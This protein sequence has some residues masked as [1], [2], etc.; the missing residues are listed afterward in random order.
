MSD[1]RMVTGTGDASERQ[2]EAALRPRRLAEYIGQPKLKE[3]LG[4]YLQ[5]AARRGDAL[6]HVLLCGPPGLGKTTLAHIIAAEMGVNIRVT[7]GPLIEKAGDL[8]ALLTNLEPRDTLFIDEIHRLSPAVEEILYP[9]MEDFKLDLLVGQGPGARTITL[10]LQPFTLIGATTRMG[11][12]SGPLR[13]RFGINFHMDFY[14]VKDLQVIVERSARLLLVP[15]EGNASEELAR[16]SRGTPRVANRLLRRVRDYAQ[17]LGDGAV[18]EA[19][20]RD[21][22]ERMEVDRFGLDDVDRRILLTILEK[23]RGGPVGLNTIAASIGEEADSVEEIYEPY[24]MQIGFLERTPR[25]RRITA[26]A[27]EHLGI[28]LP[29]GTVPALFDPGAP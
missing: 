10:P 24:L 8:A 14:P 15:L 16:R 21:S 5:A 6:D 3:N 18:D 23:F 17:I 4:I 20:A 2:W 19:M 29:G 25:G 28:P 11:L 27:C 1:D 13:N 22:L 26:R 12:L 9:A 7:S